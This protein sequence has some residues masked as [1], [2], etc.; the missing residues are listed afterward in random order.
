MAGFGGGLGWNFNIITLR[1]QIHS[2]VWL[3]HLL[4]YPN[5]L[6]EILDF[7]DIDLRL[8][9]SHYELEYERVCSGGRRHLRET[10]EVFLDH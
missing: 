9:S 4:N 3:E 5:L 8:R 6:S 2:K 10:F 7:L 1:L